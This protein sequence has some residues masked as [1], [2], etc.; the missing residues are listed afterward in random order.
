MT[1]ATTTPQGCLKVGDRVHVRMAG[2]TAFW[3][4]LGPGAGDCP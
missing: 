4:R 3:P 1:D 2:L